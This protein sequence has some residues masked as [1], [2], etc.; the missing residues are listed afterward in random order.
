MRVASACVERQYMLSCTEGRLGDAVGMNRCLGLAVHASWPA[1]HVC[2]QPVLNRL[3]RS[4]AAQRTAEHKPDGRRVAHPC[5]LDLGAPAADCAPER[6]PVGVRRRCIG[7]PAQQHWISKCAQAPH[8]C[9]ACMRARHWL[10]CMETAPAHKVAK[11][12]S[13]CKRTLNAASQAHTQL[14]HGEVWR[15]VRTSSAPTLARRP[16]TRAP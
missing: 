16:R 14:A 2:V 12:G 15:S 4:G 3:R 5:L 9:H 11:Q 6:Q 1:L 10:L 13:P 8:G 7:Q